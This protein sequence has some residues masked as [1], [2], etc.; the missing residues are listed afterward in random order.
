MDSDLRQRFWSKV[1]IVDD[2]TSCWEW[3]A[4]I[5]DGYGKFHMPYGNERAHR[6]A[7]ELEKGRIPEGEEVMH[8]CDNRKC[9]RPDHL[10]SGTKQQ[11]MADMMAKSRQAKGTQKWTA[12]LTEENVLE[13]RRRHAAGET[14]VSLSTEF[15]IGEKNASQLACGDTWKHVGGPRRKRRTFKC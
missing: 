14:L 15:K 2:D 1:K 4:G 10:S 11:N 9:C 3:Q 8:S 5:Q 6:V 13:I 7:Y 12:K